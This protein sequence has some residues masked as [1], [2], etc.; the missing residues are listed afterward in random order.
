MP[1]IIGCMVFLNHENENSKQE[2]LLNFE[3]M[4]DKRG[5]NLR[6]EK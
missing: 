4:I 5:K 6:F 1:C 2:N 3:K